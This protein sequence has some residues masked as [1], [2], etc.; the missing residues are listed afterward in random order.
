MKFIDYA[1]SAESQSRW[2]AKYKAFPSTPRPTAPRPRSDRP[3]DEDSVD[4]SKGFVH[5]IKWWSQ[6][7][8]K[9]GQVWSKWI[10]S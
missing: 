2:L 5:D 10:I 8:D 3:G 7:R 1:S 4:R 6:N 9:V